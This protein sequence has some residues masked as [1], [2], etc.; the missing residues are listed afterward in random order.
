MDTKQN[1]TSFFERLATLKS[2]LPEVFVESQ[3][4]ARPRLGYFKKCGIVGAGQLGAHPENIMTLASQR[5]NYRFREI[6]ISQKPHLRG[7]RPGF[8][9]VGEVTRIRQTGENIVVG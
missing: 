6:F 8:K 1:H 3:Y 4:D 7:Y 9:F 5:F 2:N